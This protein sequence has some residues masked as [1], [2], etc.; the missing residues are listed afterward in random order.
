VGSLP[1]QKIEMPS[2]FA[3]FFSLQFHQ[4]YKKWRLLHEWATV[5]KIIDM[6]MR[7]SSLDTGVVGR[8][9]VRG[10]QHLEKYP[11]EQLLFL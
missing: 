6:T 7:V 10:V 5:F 4:R 2:I 1:E 11:C 9:T 8:N 3:G